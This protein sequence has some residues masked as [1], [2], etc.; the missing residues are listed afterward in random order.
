LKDCH[1]L[2]TLR[3]RQ[4]QSTQEES[5]HSSQGEK[6]I[7]VQYYRWIETGPGLNDTTNRAAQKKSEDVVVCG[8][9]DMAFSLIFLCMDPSPFPVLSWTFLTACRGMTIEL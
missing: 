5:E 7:V 9:R 4:K 1:R 3:K 8:K 2:H 6:T